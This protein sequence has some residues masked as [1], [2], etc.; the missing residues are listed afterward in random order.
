M[1]DGLPQGQSC[2]QFARAL[3]PERPDHIHRVDDAG[4]RHK[5]TN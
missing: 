3:H 1:R 4:Q 2:S 5:Q